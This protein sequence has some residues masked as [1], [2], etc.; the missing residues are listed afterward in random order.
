MSSRL[1]SVLVTA[2]LLAATSVQAAGLR[3]GG[4]LAET[5][6]LVFVPDVPRDPTPGIGLASPELRFGF[7][8]RAGSTLLLESREGRS[9]GLDLQLGLAPA[10]DGFGRLGGL[11]LASLPA[12]LGAPSGEGAS[13][14][15]IGGAL[16]WSGWTVGGT[17]VTGA[18]SGGQLDLWTGRVGYGPVAAR[19]GYGQEASFGR[20][21]RELW[22][23]GTD[24]VTGS[25]LTLEGD[26]AVTTQPDREPTTIGRIGLRLN[27]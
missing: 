19:L 20:A 13:G 6:E 14:L 3:A 15:A 27:F 11:G 24:L 5:G 2:S 10:E 7:T 12:A 18:V 9:R 26:L 4:M 17:F 1:L 21:E 23:F 16:A 25:W 8:P 22:L